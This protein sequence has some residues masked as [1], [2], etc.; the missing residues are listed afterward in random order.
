MVPKTVRALKHADI[1]YY[2]FAHYGSWVKLRTNNPLERIMKEIR[3]RTR[4]VDAFPDGRSCLNLAAA[5][6]RHI[7]GGQ[8]STPRYMN[9][10][11]LY[12]V[13][14]SKRTTHSPYIQSKQAS[15]M[16]LKITAC[17]TLCFLGFRYRRGSVRRGSLL[18]RCCVSSRKAVPWGLISVV[19]S[20]QTLGA[21]DPATSERDTLTLI[22][23]HR[24]NR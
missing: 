12:A 15:L 24:L 1:P 19:E 3:Q 22:S 13:E 8:R 9:M 20:E 2:F 14:A 4:V 18:I 6:L 5:R 21:A 17:L 11:P 16:T 23:V 10:A 7:A